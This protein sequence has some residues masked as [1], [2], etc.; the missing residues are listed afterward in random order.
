MTYADIFIC[1]Y[2]LLG[3]DILRSAIP[4]RLSHIDHDSLYSY[5]INYVPGTASKTFMIPWFYII[6]ITY[7]YDIKYTY[8]NNAYSRMSEYPSVTCYIYVFEDYA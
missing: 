3:Y 7:L 6:S 8:M 4:L 1:K 5:M 2:L